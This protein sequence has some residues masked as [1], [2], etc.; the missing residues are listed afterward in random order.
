MLDDICCL[1]T[2]LPEDIEKAKWCGDFARAGR[3]IAQ[4]LQNPKTPAFLRERLA[5][6]QEI[7]LRLPLDYCYS[8][9]EA[10]R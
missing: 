8:E 3:L 2:Q 9:P 6:E 5:L 7:L 4:R 10:L 1:E